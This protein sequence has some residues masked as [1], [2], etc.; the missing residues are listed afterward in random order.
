MIRDRKLENSFMNL[1]PMI[2]QSLISFSFISYSVAPKVTGMLLELELNEILNLLDNR[3]ALED[4]IDEAFKVI[5]SL[6]QILYYYRFFRVAVK[7]N[8]S[9]TR[10][11][12]SETNN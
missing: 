3:P 12:L 6:D 2:I 11:F 8:K 4:R 1:P 10:E 9:I 5:Y 7:M